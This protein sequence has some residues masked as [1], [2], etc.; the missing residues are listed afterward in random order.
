M[1]PPTRVLPPRDLP[2]AAGLALGAAADLLLA[3]PPRWHPVAGFGRAAAALERAVWR[4]SRAAGAGYAALLTGGAAGLGVVLDRA[5][6]G[7]PVPRTLVTAA[8]T[9][10]VLGGTSLARAGTAMARTLEAG[11]LP[12]ARALLPTLA[13][14]DPS[15]LDAPELARATVESVAENTSDAAV[16]PLLWGA[17]AGLPGLLGYRAVNTLDAMVGHRSPRHLRF[18][19]AAARTDDVANWLPARLTAALTVATAPAAGGSA[20]GAW[21]AWQRDGAAHPSPNAGRCEAALAGALDLRLGGRNVYGSRVEDRPSLGNGRSPVA[22]D[23]PRAVRL[24]GAVWTAA[25]VLA[26]AARTLPHR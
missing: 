10:A 7:R 12:A 16:A 22:A 14:R 5:T 3:D 26:A 9:W 4:D 15:R 13:G 21:T 25:A 20:R 1:H 11:D 6:R 24:S 2:T 17:L 23:V 18:G 8:A 19:W